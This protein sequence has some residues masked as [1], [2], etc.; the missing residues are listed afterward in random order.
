M[1]VLFFIIILQMSVIVHVYF[2][3][4]FL[5]KGQDRDFR[6]FFVTTVINIFMGIFISIF[7][8][9]FPRQLRDINLDRLLF[10]E[11]GV[12]FV[13][14]IYIKVRITRNIMRKRKDPANYHFNAF[15]KKV[16]HPNTT[17]FKD[18]V[19]YFL[20]LPFTLICGA[21]FVTRLSC[22]R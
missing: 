16:F 22:M 12:I 5:S 2:L 21:Y 3:V 8:I 14:M 4:N 9:M 19:S 11:S 7:I 15:G 6:G 13:V 10:I 17:T 18:V 1:I 20:T